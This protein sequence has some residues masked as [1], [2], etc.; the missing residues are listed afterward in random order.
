MTGGALRA[1]FLGD[2]PREIGDCGFGIQTGEH[3]VAAWIAGEPRDPR[4]AVI[5]IA[6]HDRVGRARLLARGDDVAVT[7]RAILEPRLILRA[8]D[9]LYAERA[10]LHHALLAHRD[11]GIEQ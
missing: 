10:F 6:E 1:G 7:H 2:D 3:V 5:E 4:A 11:V 9:A 8:T